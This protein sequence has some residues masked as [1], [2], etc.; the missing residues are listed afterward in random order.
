MKIRARKLSMAKAP[1]ELN[2]GLMV[3]ACFNDVREHFFKNKEGMESNR[4]TF[5]HSKPVHFR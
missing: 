4:F 2:H 5:H 3:R 1:V